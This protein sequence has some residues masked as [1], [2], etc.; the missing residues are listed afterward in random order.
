MSKKDFKK[1]CERL[2]SLGFIQIEL[3]PYAKRAKYILNGF[4]K[5]V[6]AKK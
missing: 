6:G 4:V 1:E 5:N 3:E 2:E